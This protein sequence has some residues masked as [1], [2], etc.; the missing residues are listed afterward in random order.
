MQRPREA[1][2]V[3]DELPQRDS[4]RTERAA[5]DGVVGIAFDMNDRRLDVA[6]LVAE[7]VNDHAASHRAIRADAVGFGGA[8]DLEFPGLRERRR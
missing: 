3:D 6:R 8:R 2:V 1:L 4:L 5:I 7:R